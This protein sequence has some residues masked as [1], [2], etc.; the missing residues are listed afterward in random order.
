MAKSVMVAGKPKNINELQELRGPEETKRPEEVR[1]PDK[2]GKPGEPEPRRLEKAKKQEKLKPVAGLVKVKGPKEL[3]VALLSS[4]S[5]YWQ[6]LALPAT[7][8][9]YYFFFSIA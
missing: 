9:S 8:F 6:A 7:H 5:N 1:R 4:W 3:A 2:I